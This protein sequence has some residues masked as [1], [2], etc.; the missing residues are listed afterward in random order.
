[1]YQEKSAAVKALRNDEGGYKNTRS[2]KQFLFATL[3]VG[4]MLVLTRDIR[5]HIFGHLTGGK[6]SHFMKECSGYGDDTGPT[7][8]WDKV[9][10]PLREINTIHTSN[11]HLAYA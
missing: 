1:M 9:G 5:N 4:G 10:V 2:F 7:F 3:L 8:E 11:R 6:A